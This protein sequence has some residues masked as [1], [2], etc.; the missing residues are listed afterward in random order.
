MP[1][2]AVY[3]QR[4]PCFISFL[5]LAIL[6]SVKSYVDLNRVQIIYQVLDIIWCIWN[7]VYL[8]VNA[9]IFHWHRIAPKTR[10]YPYEALLR[11]LL[12]WSIHSIRKILRTYIYLVHS[13]YMYLVHYHIVDTGGK[14][15]SIL[16]TCK[17]L[18]TDTVTCSLRFC[19]IMEKLLLTS[20]S[21]DQD[22]PIDQD[23]FIGFVLS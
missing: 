4:V 5:I 13:Q 20:F 12:T 18:G 7:K 14:Q 15:E 10:F 6:G 2:T 11:D 1:S 19:G 22:I 23:I 8:F 9:K 16:E 17:S 3:P 21:K